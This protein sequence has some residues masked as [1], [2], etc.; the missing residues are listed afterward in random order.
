MKEKILAKR[1]AEAYVSYAREN[2]STAKIVEEMK[3]LKTVIRNNPEVRSFV[4][5][6][7]I[8]FTEKCAFVEDVLDDHFSKE[9]RQFIKM[10]LSKRRIELMVEI[11][12]Y[13]RI[14]YSHAEAIDALI[15]TSYPLDLELIQKIEKKLEKKFNH[16]LNFYLDL[17]A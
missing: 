14:H 9:A 4:E 13:I 16:K 11:I 10:L 12:D 15:K 8:T 5:N 6:P 17:D 3:G 2:L 1:Y 7:E